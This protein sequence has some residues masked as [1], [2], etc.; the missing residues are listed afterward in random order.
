MENNFNF[1]AAI[2]ELEEIS[3][4]F[5][6]EEINLDEGLVKFKKGTALIKKCH[7]HLK[8]VENQFVEIKKEIENEEDAQ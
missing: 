1:S 5:Q 7:Q 6:S 3:R 2:K 8:E 4:W